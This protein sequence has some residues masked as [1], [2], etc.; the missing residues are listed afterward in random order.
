MATSIL[1]TQALWS[2]T[3]WAGNYQYG[4]AFDD[5]AANS[6]SLRLAEHWRLHRQRPGRLSGFRRR[7]DERAAGD[8]DGHRCHRHAGG[9][10]VAQQRRHGYMV[11]VNGLYNNGPFQGG[12]A[13]EVHNNFRPNS[14]PVLAL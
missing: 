10:T 3:G 14:I 2:N 5:R 13:Y 1:G 12:I 9:T 11:S 8:Y 7:S 4:G 6:H